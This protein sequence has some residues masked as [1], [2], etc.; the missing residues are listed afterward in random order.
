MTLNRMLISIICEVFMFI[1][2]GCD[3]MVSCSVQIKLPA[4]IENENKTKEV[5]NDVNELVKIEATKQNFNL[6]A[7][8]NNGNAKYVYGAED[9]PLSI[10]IFLCEAQKV[11]QV[12]VEEMGR[13][14][15][16]KEA[17][18]LCTDLAKIL[19]S[20]YRKEQIKVILISSDCSCKER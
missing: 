3:P 5:L 19:N 14:K 1:S 8:P 6:I 4:S 9:K 20:K 2:A 15:I 7:S 18:D 12:K 17:S 10:T 16:R 13:I 11:I